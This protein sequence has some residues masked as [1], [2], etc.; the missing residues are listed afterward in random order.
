MMQRHIEGLALDSLIVDRKPK[1]TLEDGPSLVVTMTYGAR[2][3]VTLTNGRRFRWGG[4]CRT[5]RDKA[6]CGSAWSDFAYRHVC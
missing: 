4:G 2:W 3:D 6:A 1:I 5:E